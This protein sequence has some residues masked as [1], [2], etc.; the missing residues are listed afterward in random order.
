MI[1]DTNSVRGN[2]IFSSKIK[3]ISRLHVIYFHRKIE[4]SYVGT[5]ERLEESSPT[6]LKAFKLNV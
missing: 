1:V 6:V 3:F 2:E 4:K 5:Y